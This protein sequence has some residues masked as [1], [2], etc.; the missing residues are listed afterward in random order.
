MH[1]RVAAVSSQ[2]LQKNP[3]ERSPTRRRRDRREAESSQNIAEKGSQPDDAMASALSLQIRH[4]FPSAALNLPPAAAKSRFLIPSSSLL[5]SSP[6]PPSPHLPRASPDAGPG[7]NPDAGGEDPAA[8]PAEQDADFENRLS[9][10]RLKYRSGTGKKA[11]QRRSKKSPPGATSS[12]KGGKVLLPPVSLLEP[13]SAGGMKVEFGFSPYSEWLNGRLAVLGLA[14]L[15]LVE[16]AS[17]KGLLSYHSPP[18]IFIQI[19]TI[20]AAAAMFV[21]FEKE[22]V[23]VWPKAPPPSPSA[24]V[25]E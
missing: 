10:I 16:L 4:I 11:E 20:S 5:L 2:G 7:E 25:G 12:K 6:N 24:S 3:N 9:Q 21:K 23:S 19:Y 18:I 17:G 1:I 14:A 8:A 15:L 13:V 22:K